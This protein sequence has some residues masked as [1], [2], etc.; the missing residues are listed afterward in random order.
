MGKNAG[1]AAW[2]YIAKALELSVKVL[3]G[4]TALTK[5]VFQVGPE[6]ESNSL[7][8]HLWSVFLVAQHW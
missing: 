6:L 8:K 5:E 1:K 7:N 2:G 3:Q 4:E